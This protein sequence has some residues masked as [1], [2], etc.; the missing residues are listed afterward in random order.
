MESPFDWGYYRSHELRAFG[1]KAVG[2]N[3]SIAK[4]CK[5]I[6]LE[7]ITLGDDCRVDDFTALIAT[8]PL[9]IGNRVHIHSYCQIGSR[10]SVTLD[11]YSALASGCLVYSASDDAMG[12]YMVGGVVPEH[13]TKPKI[14]PVRL[15]RHA[16]AFARCTI[17]PGVTMH[18]GAIACA[19]S[20]V[21]RSLPEWMIAQ[22]SP[23]IARIARP[24]TAL[25]LEA[26]IAIPRE[27]VA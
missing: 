22:G 3:V 10:G 19:H 8:G 11:D 27:Q 6:G 15:A 24:R 13:C 17:L 2:E 26:S 20:L 21:S 7:N 23:A 12:R 4:T 18:E 25:R 5:I 1:F 16:V 14:A 9:V